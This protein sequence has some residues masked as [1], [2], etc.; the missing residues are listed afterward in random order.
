[1]LGTDISV[2]KYLNKNKMTLVEEGVE[3]EYKKLKD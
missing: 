2:I 3:T 1:M